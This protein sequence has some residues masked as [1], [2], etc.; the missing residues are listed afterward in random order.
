V[1]EV[2]T[3][4]QKQLPLGASPFAAIELRLSL[5][6]TVRVTPGFEAGLW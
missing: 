6:D 1:I 4:I 5:R 3:L 2:S